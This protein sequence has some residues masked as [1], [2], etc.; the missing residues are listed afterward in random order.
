[1]PLIALMV[2]TDMGYELFNVCFYTY[3]NKDCI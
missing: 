3:Y 2:T 1:M